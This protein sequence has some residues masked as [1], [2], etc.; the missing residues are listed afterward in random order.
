[1]SAIDAYVLLAIG[2][3]LMAVEI[4]LF[5]F[6]FFWMGLGF[7][8]IGLVSMAVAFESGV[9]QIALAMT[10]GVVFVVLLR[11][12]MVA[13]TQKSQTTPEEHAHT[14]GMGIVEHGRIKL[15][16]TYWQCDDDLKG[17]HDGDRVEVRIED[18]RAKLV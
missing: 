12:K 14:G 9:V 17:Y 4:F 7:L 3:G 15:D 1:M 2:V 16:G 18:N 11:A 10:I 13:L 8:L 5:S 6:Y